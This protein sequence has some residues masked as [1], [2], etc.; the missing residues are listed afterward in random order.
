MCWFPSRLHWILWYLLTLQE[1]AEYRRRCRRRSLP[2]TVDD[3][4]YEYIIICSTHNSSKQLRPFEC[5]MWYAASGVQALSRSGSGFY[6]YGR[7]HSQQTSKCDDGAMFR[8]RFSLFVYITPLT[9]VATAA[10]AKPK[11]CSICVRL[12]TDKYLGRTHAYPL[13]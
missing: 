3:N 4:D 2:Q 8:V 10:A 9:G 5:T 1:F 11:L 7:Q 13:T 6:D 12:R